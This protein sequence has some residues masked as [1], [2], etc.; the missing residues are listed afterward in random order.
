MTQISD[1]SFRTTP[2]FGHPGRTALPRSR[3]LTSSVSVHFA[4]WKRL[5]ACALLRLRPV[6]LLV[7]SALVTLAAV[8]GKADVIQLPAKPSSHELKYAATA[9]EKGG[10]VGMVEVESSTFSGLFNTAVPSPQNAP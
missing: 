10:V 3:G 2:A 5:L 7:V 8:H 6:G 9:F 4:F 1:S